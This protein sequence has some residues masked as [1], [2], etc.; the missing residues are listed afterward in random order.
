MNRSN[1]Q[2]QD[3]KGTIPKTLLEKADRLIE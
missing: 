2:P 1:D 3:G